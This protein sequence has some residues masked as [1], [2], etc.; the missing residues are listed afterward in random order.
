MP[1]PSFEDTV[2]CPTSPMN[3]T[4]TEHW[5]S[6]TIPG[7]P[8]LHHSCNTGSLGV[9]ANF[10]GN[11]YARTGDAYALIITNDTINTQ[12]GIEY[13]RVELTEYLIAEKCYRASFFFSVGDI[14]MYSV[15]S[16]DIGMQFTDTSIISPNWVQIY[17]PT[18]TIID[19]NCIDTLNTTD[20]IEVSGE[21]IAQGGEKF[22]TIGV[23]HTDTF[24]SSSTCNSIYFP[25]SIGG[26]TYIDDVSVIPC[27][28]D[29][30]SE[31]K[32]ECINGICVDTVSNGSFN[33]LADCEASCEQVGIAEQNSKKQLLRIID[34][35]GRKSKPQPNVPLF[36]IYDDGTV[37]KRIIVE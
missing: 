31:N 28:I 35:L 7:N 33:S 29:S 12:S 1:N 2:Q 14:S 22:I 24:C 32:W 23:F 20:W 11:Q 17:D 8:D 27:P 37:E 3:I 15:L 30:T 9:P 5:I 26:T 25:G 6:A 19:T 16:R 4:D 18:N 10:C 21:Y 36:Y 13:I 34:V